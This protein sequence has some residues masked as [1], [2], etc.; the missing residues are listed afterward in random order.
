MIVGGKTS[1][2]GSGA[3]DQGP[4][5]GTWVSRDA[6]DAVAKTFSDGDLHPIDTGGVIMGRRQIFLDDV[7]NATKCSDSLLASRAKRRTRGGENMSF[8][9]RLAVMPIF[10]VW[11]FICLP[12]LIVAAADAGFVLWLLGTGVLCFAFARHSYKQGRNG[13]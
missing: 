12:I 9:Q 6:T 13:R 8:G 1:N 4:T 7:A 2:A 10:M 5:H 11:C 3:D